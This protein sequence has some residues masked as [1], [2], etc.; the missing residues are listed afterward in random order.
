MTVYSHPYWDVLNGFNVRINE[1]A[2]I[3]GQQLNLMTINQLDLKVDI[4]REIS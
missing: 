2:F 4:N 1:F 3:I